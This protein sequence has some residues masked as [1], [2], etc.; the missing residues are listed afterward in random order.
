MIHF[1]QFIIVAI[2]AAL[3]TALPFVSCHSS[4]APAQP[5]LLII[6][7]KVAVAGN[8]PF[9]YVRLLTAEL[10]EYKLVGPKAASLRRHHQNEV[11]KLEG[12]IVQ[13]AAGP[14]LPAEFEVTRIF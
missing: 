1:R 5:V 11:V 13:P 6:T 10:Q 9:S 7:G 4:S 8:E 14:G 12:R 3:T 2:A